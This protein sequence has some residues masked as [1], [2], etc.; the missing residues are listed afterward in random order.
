MSALA[1]GIGDV[2]AAAVAI[3]GAVVFDEMRELPRL[4]ASQ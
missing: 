1:I 4:L 2:R 3:N